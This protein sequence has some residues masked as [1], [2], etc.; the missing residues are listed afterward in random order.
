MHN[1]TSDIVDSTIYT[2]L[3]NQIAPHESGVSLA[4]LRQEGNVKRATSML[5]EAAKIDCRSFVTPNDVAN[6]TYKLNLAFVANLFNKY[7][8]LPDPGADDVLEEELVEETR[9]EKTY[10]N[11]MNS[12][13]VK[14]HV[15]YLFTDLQNGLIIFQV[16]FSLF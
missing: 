6:A 1:F 11:W 14:P 7:P 13:G 15:G 2:Y 12:L 16:S 10:R 9:E 4:P 8:A 5:N 3:L